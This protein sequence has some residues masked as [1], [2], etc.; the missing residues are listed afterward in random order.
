[1]D[2][3]RQLTNFFSTFDLMS[4]ANVKKACSTLT[5]AF[6]DVSINLIPYSTA[7]C[8]PLS[9]DTFKINKIIIQ[10]CDKIK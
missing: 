1:M 4:L 8:S 2:K 6:A 7:S 10:N 3:K 9:F 5:D